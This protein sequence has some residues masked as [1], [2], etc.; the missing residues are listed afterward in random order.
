MVTLEFHRM[1]LPPRIESWATEGMTPT[2]RAWLDHFS[3][4]WA[5]TDWPGSLSNLFL[6]PDFIPEAKLRKEYLKSRLIPKRE[7]LTIETRNTNDLERPFNWQ[8]QRWK[9]VAYRAGVHLGD[10]VRL[11]LEQLRWHRALDS[12]RTGLTQGQ[13]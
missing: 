2:L 6:A 11:P 1:S 12:V 10:L 5:L 13:S 7:R 9:Y 4:D 3:V 8:I